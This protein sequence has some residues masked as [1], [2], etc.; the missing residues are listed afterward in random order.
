MLV[1]ILA[2]GL[3]ATPLPAEA[4]KPGKV[5]PIGYLSGAETG[6]INLMLRGQTH[7]VSHDGVSTMDGTARGAAMS[8]PGDVPGWQNI[9]WGMTESQVRSAV[10]RRPS[11]VIEEYADGYS[12][13]KVPVHIR[14]HLLYAFPIFSNQTGR[15]VRVQ[16][17]P[18]A[19]A[20]GLWDALYE[21]LEERYGKPAERDTATRDTEAYTWRFPTTTIRLIRV[22]LLVPR[23][24]RA[25]LI[26]H[27]AGIP[28]APS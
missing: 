8:V 5:Y 24:R 14:S 9:R 3:L 11:E 20:Y 18:E 15:L 17:R 10:G 21:W 22:N 2:P 23:I 4:P 16:I 27:R 19:P 7:A 25:V 6:R 13:M 28:R 26:Y 12:P 1:V